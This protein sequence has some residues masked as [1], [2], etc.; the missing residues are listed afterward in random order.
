[1]QYFHT[2]RHKETLK[3]IAKR[4]QVPVTSIIASNNLKAPHTI[5]VG[6][7]LSI[8]AG[9]KEYHVRT[10]DSVYR[11]AQLYGLPISIIVEANKLTPPYLLYENQVLKIPPG[12]PFYVV[13]EGD[14]L[15][16]IARR[17]NV[18]TGKRSDIDAIQKLNKLQNTT[19]SPGMKLNIPYV[20][21]GNSGFIAYTSNRGGQFDIWTY[22]L[23]NGENNQLT[24]GLGDLFSIPIWSPDSSRIAFVGK[25]RIIYVIYVTSGSIGAIDQLTDGE[26]FGL[27]WSPDSV[28]LAYVAR[29]NIQVYNTTLH[30]GTI[31]EQPGASEV[32]WFPSGEELLFQA[33]D[34][35]GVSQ[36]YKSGLIGTAKE[37]ITHNE[38]GLLQ[39]VQLSPDGSFV[40]YTTPGASISIIHTIDLATGQVYEIK[41]GPQSKNYYPDWSPDSLNIAYSATDFANNSYFSQIRTVNRKGSNDQIWA[42]SNC[43]STP[44]TWSPDGSKLAYL[45]GCSETEFAKEMWMIDLTHPA[46]IKLLDGFTITSLN[47]S[48]KPVLDL[49]KKDY[50]NEAFDVNFQYPADWEKVNDVRYVGDDGFFQISAIYGSENIDEICHDEAFQKL[51]PYGSTPKIIPSENQYIEA[52][53]ILPSS[54]QPR[55]M[56]EQAA[57]IV[58][59]PEPIELDGNLYNYIILWA[60]KNHIDA[61]SSTL[62]FLP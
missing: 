13:E 10:G 40:L 17:Y 25:N 14:S 33:L 55:E 49:A 21:P 53:T 48:P 41:G 5:S 58:K 3:D 19:I 57:Y 42:I 60:D 6:E 1:M 51:K 27:D 61:I 44:V 47:W 26:D 52:C 16:K 54:D 31:V 2:V 39:N 36:L 22:N 29:G 9:V 7:Q 32:S 4:W 12:V 50:T 59:Y 46:P 24:S 20:P 34:A 35:S 15:D 45:S 62:L 37:Q 11:I 56:N 30:E 43:F 38:N 23:R 28:H 8:P 18:L